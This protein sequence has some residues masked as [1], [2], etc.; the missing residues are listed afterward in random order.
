MRFNWKPVVVIILQAIIAA[1]TAT[2]AVSVASWKGC[3]A[4]PSPPTHRDVPPPSKDVTSAIGKIA[5]SGGYC[6]GTVVGP[7]RGD[8]RWH[9]VTASHCVKRVG[10]AVTFLPRSGSAVPCKV[11]AID[12]RPD[13]A[14]IVTDAAD[15]ELPYTT[16]ADKSPQEGTPI[17]HSGFGVDKPG[18][19][20]NGQVTGFNGDRGQ[21]Q[22]RLSVSPGDSGGGII[23]DADGKL[24][25]PVCC[26]TCLGCVGDVWGGSPENIRLL[27]SNPTQF[28]DLPPVAMPEPPQ[29]MP[30]K[31]D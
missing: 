5:M 10:E 16:I 28:L 24:L 4:T 29:R 22:Y 19:R 21:L 30:Q 14:I 11:T 2:T 18:N 25:S 31:K 6:S 23:T 27:I 26:T 8:G 15:I 3:S 17:W 1:L 20:E 13:I 9:I 12:R 7:R